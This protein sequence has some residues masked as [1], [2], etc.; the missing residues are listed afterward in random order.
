MEK[1]KQALK[2]LGVSS[3]TIDEL[4]EQI[5]YTRLIVHD[6]F[7]RRGVKGDYRNRAIKKMINLNLNFSSEQN[8]IY[9]M[10]VDYIKVICPKCNA[11]LNGSTGGGTYNSNST[12][13]KCEKCGTRVILTFPNDGISV[14]FKD[15]LGY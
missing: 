8:I 11:V 2:D 7:N 6:E 14:Q 12:H 13:Y 5:D 1:L 4:D 10:T 15:S 9:N 3:K